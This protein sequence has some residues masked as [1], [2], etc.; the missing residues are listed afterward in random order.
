MLSTL[1]RYYNATPAAKGRDKGRIAKAGEIAP[2][3][4]SEGNELL[5]VLSNDRRIEVRREF[6]AGTLAAADPPTGAV[7]MV[8]CIRPATKI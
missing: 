8:F 3:R 4:N 2:L 5:V 1:A 7:L 6:D